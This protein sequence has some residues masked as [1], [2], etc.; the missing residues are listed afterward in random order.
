MNDYNKR[1]KRPLYL[2]SL[3]YNRPKAT[4]V[5]VTAAIK[6]HHYIDCVV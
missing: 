1:G 2:S 5:N 3:A 4:A 6:P